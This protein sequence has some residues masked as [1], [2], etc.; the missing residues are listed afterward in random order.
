MADSQKK[1][2]L[3]SGLEDQLRHNDVRDR[4][5][6][7]LA[8]ELTLITDL[9]H[10]DRESAR[11][12]VDVGDFESAIFDCV[13]GARSPLPL[14]LLKRVESLVKDGF[15]GDSTDDVVVSLS[16]HKSRVHTDP[17]LQRLLD[18]LQVA[19]ATTEQQTAAVRHWL[20]G[21]KLIFT[22]LQSLVEGGFGDLIKQEG[23]PSR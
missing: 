15:F 17:F 19:E 13:V 10:A 7:W 23:R 16:W 20:R 3:E 21:R 5:E 2:Q 14:Q 8:E 22:A 6:G 12:D 11:S 4:R 1:Q 18:D 9:R